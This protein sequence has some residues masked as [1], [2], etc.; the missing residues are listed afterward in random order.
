MARQCNS[1]LPRAIAVADYILEGKGH[2]I[3]DAAKEFRF[4]KSTIGR[5]INYLGTVAFYSNRADSKEL[6]IKYVKVKKTL[7]KLA[8]E[9]SANNISKW[10][11]RKSASK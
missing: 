2:S 11:A 6:K 3:M 8:K 1:N 9:N 7:Q 4:S 10:N 5:D